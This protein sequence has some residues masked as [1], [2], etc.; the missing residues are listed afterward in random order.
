MDYS[1][2]DL[3]EIIKVA[4]KNGAIDLTLGEFSISFSG[5]PAPNVLPGSRPITSEEE[6][7]HLEENE[8][9]LRSRELEEMRLADPEMYEDLIMRKELEDARKEPDGVES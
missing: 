6:Q 2:K 4:A 8:Y 9:Q 1:V 3:C 7:E 5:K